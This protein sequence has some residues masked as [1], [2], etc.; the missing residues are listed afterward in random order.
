M[1]KQHSKKFRKKH[2][3]PEQLRNFIT[4]IYIYTQY[5]KNLLRKKHQ[6][7]SLILTIYKCIVKKSE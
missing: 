1:A 6:K 3:H 7:M 5:I 2:N 4:N